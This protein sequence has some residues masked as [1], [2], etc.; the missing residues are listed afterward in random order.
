MY[1]TVS[2]TFTYVCTFTCFFSFPP[3]AR[4]RLVEEVTIVQDVHRILTYFNTYVYVRRS[5]CNTSFYM[6]H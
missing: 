5:S 6:M 3:I 1:M 4:E 2:R